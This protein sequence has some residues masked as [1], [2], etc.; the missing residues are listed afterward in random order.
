MRLVRAP[1]SAD[2][3]TVFRKRPR[4]PPTSPTKTLFRQL[5]P[6]LSQSSKST[7]PE[8]ALCMLLHSSLPLK[9]GSA[10]VAFR[11]PALH[12]YKVTSC[13]V[14]QS[15]RQISW[16]DLLAPRV[17][18]SQP[19]RVSNYKFTRLPNYKIALPI[20]LPQYNINTPNRR[21]HIGDQVSFA[22]TR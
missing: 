3:I 11:E 17:S 9:F 21:H 15:E 14:S 7:Q 5:P 2:P 12:L 6:R 8:N 10:I 4:N 13:I 20:N 16:S 1:L 18:W 19:L 22:H